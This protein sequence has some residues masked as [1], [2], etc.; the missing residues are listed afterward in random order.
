[1]AKKIKKDTFRINIPCT[2]CFR[3]THLKFNF[4]FITY[5]KDVGDKEK[6]QILKRIRELSEEPYIIVANYGREI[7]FEN[8]KVDI[9]KEIDPKFF[10]GHRNFDGK[11]TIIRLYTNNNPTKG[12]IIGKIINKVFYIFYIDVKG[13]LYSH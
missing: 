1:M 7:G 4:S 3:P 13:E 2:E 11:Y 6:V 9:R 8:V 5:E 12:R 10:S